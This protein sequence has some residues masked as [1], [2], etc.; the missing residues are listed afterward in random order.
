M[1]DTALYRNHALL[2]RLQRNVVS[3]RALLFS[4]GFTT[5]GTMS[6]TDC[7]CGHS[8]TG[9]MAYRYSSKIVSA[10]S[11]AASVSNGLTRHG[12]TL[13]RGA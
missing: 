3:L 10:G 12:R 8:R 4:I 13:N 6:L 2:V 11:Y 5:A 7:P 9:N 1:P